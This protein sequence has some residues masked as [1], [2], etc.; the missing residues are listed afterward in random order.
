MN[1]TE[2]LQDLRKSLSGLPQGEIDE[3]IS[4]YEEMIDDR[5]EEGLTEEEAIEAIGPVNTIVLQT[6]S[7]T[8]L[9]KIVKER[10]S[11]KRRMK[12]W[13]I[14]LIVLGSPIWL[15]LLIG[16]IAVLISVYVVLWSVVISMWAVVISFVA[17]TIAGIAGGIFLCSRSNLTQGLLFVSAGLVLAGLSVYAFYGCKAATKALAKVSA[18]I[19]L[20]VKRWFVR[21]EAD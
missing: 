8:P 6:I 2:F 20:R 15:S 13:E 16:A 21:K 11:P 7:D 18:G 10:V 3:R 4:F 5:V 17:G 14:V 12:I 19:A 1:K 9:T